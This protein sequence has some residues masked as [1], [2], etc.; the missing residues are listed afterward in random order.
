L[1]VVPTVSEL[2]PV[3]RIEIP[4]DKDGMF[5]TPVKPE[6]V[7]KRAEQWIT[8]VNYEP[9]SLDDKPWVASTY[10]DADGNKRY[11][12]HQLHVGQV[13]ECVLVYDRG[14]R[15]AEKRNELFG[16]VRRITQTTVVIDEYPSKAIA[17]ECGGPA[18]PAPANEARRQELENRQAAIEAEHAQ[19]AAENRKLVAASKKLKAEWKD[20][21]RALESFDP[22]VTGMFDEDELQDEDEPQIE[23]TPSSVTPTRTPIRS[24]PTPGRNELCSCGSGKKFKKCCIGKQSSA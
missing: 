7:G 24:A 19:I 17:L 5:T 2:R 8:R 9:M 20:L 12:A 10:P 14:Q 23:E 11:Y 21:Q 13:L 18:E 16:V 4:I 15:W 6:R 22:L 3:R 1:N